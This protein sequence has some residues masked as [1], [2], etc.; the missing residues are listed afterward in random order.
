MYYTTLNNEAIHDNMST[1]ACGYDGLTWSLNTS[2]GE[3]VSLGSM[4]QVIEQVNTLGLNFV[5]L[6]AVSETQYALN[7]GDITWPDLYNNLVKSLE[8]LCEM[9]MKLLHDHRFWS[10][11]CQKFFDN[12]TEKM[13]QEFETKSEDFWEFYKK[14]SE[15]DDKLPKLH[16]MT[17]GAGSA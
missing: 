9:N 5:V 1:L 17:I 3:L 7:D 13:E 2:Q 15:I 16:M 6:L 4:Q 10:A 14:R 8:S 11:I 12:D